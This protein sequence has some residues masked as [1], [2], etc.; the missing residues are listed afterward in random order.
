V[1]AV[2]FGS[3][4][5]FEKKY[6]QVNFIFEAVPEAV[7]VP[8]PKFVF[9]HVPAPHWPLV[10][11][12]DGEKLSPVVH[13]QPKT[14]AAYNFWLETYLHDY[15][16]E[17]TYLNQKLQETVSWILDNSSQPPIIIIE[18]DHGSRAY[19]NFTSASDSCIRERFGILN[20]YYLPDNG[21]EHLY[22][23]ITPVNS[24]RVIL[25]TYFGTNLG[26][27]EDTSYFATTIHPYEFIDVTSQIDQPCIPR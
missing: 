16:R 14:L 4:L 17:V 25:D 11:G 26:L 6:A 8:G 15:P 27:L 13:P 2:F 24:F 7:T 3:D 19:L 5:R 18:G 20:A 21:S 9:I 1:A 12:P 10:F 22:D 23:S